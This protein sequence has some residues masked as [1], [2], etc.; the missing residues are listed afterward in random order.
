MGDF[1]R[2]RVWNEAT[3]LAVEVYSLSRSFPPS[4]R[5]GL[6]NQIRRAAVSISSNIA[7]GAGRGAPATFRGFIRIAR[8]SLHE[9]RSQLYLA[10][11]LGMVTAKDAEPVLKKKPCAHSGSRSSRNTYGDSH[12]S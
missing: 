1:R 7:E 4:E 6:T 10:I 3:T 5:F 2:L 8:G 11:E 9:V 12:C